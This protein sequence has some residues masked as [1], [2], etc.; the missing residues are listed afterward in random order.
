MRFVLILFLCTVLATNPNHWQEQ[1]MWGEIGLC[2]WFAWEIRKRV[3]FIPA[4]TFAYFAVWGIWCVYRIAPFGLEGF[5]L[6]METHT[7]TARS[8]LYLLLVVLPAVFVNRERVHI[9]LDVFALFAIVDSWVMIYNFFKTGSA[10]GLIGMDSVDGTFI[11][12]IAP[13]LWLDKDAHLH[14]KINFIS[15]FSI[16]PAASLSRSSTVLGLA[17]I[18]C[19][20]YFI[21]RMKKNL[22]HIALAALPL[23][24][25]MGLGYLVMGNEILND[26][27]RLHILV[28]SAAVFTKVNSWLWGLGTSS[29]ALI[30]PIIQ[31]TKGATFIWLHNEPLQILFEQGVVGLSLLL[32]LYVAMLVKQ[33]RNLPMLMTLVGMGFAS[34]LQP[35]FR[36][37][38][39]AI[40]LA[41][42]VRIC[43]AQCDEIEMI[44]PIKEG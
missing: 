23:I 17:C 29:F 6:E 20:L 44:K 5:N 12:L 22:F 42:I 4:L 16:I 37:L 39:F 43:F 21:F 18:Y 33:F 24:C 36:Y 13:L 2:L 14:P 1:M 32:L 26:N 3:S 9:V 31:G 19:F 11:T 27:G 28:M 38:P 35:F 30:M 40:F 10:L 25:L 34:L 15:F 7:L 41:F 8:V